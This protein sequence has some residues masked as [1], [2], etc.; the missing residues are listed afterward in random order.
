MSMTWEQHEA[1]REAYK[2]T[3]RAKRQRHLERKEPVFLHQPKT[4]K[5]RPQLGMQAR[6]ARQAERRSKA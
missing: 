3:M 5:K 1:L 6:R 2:A 4:H